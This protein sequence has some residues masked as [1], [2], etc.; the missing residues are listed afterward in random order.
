MKGINRK[1][2][3]IAM[4]GC[5]LNGVTAIAAEERV[6][7]EKIDE[8]STVTSVA[9]KERLGERRS[10]SR[11][12]NK[13]HETT[14]NYEL[15]D[16]TIVE[17]RILSTKGTFSENLERVFSKLDLSELPSGM[18]IETGA[19]FQYEAIQQKSGIAKSKDTDEENDISFTFSEMYAGLAKSANGNI[20]S[21]REVQQKSKDNFKKYNALPLAVSIVNYE[22]VDPKSIEDGRL[23][24]VNGKL[25]STSAEPYWE[26]NTFVDAG[27]LSLYEQPCDFSQMMVMPSDMFLT[28]VDVRGKPIVL[29]SA[30]MSF[31]GGDVS[32]DIKPDTPFSIPADAALLD[33]NQEVGFV[34]TLQTSA[35]SYEVQ[36]S[37]FFNDCLTQYLATVA[38][39]TPADGYSWAT[40]GPL[41][42]LDPAPHCDLPVT[43]AN[44]PYKY[45]KG[46][47][48]PRVYPA[49][50]DTADCDKLNRVMVL[51]DGIDIKNNR[52]PATL[53]ANFGEDINYFL[54]Q[55]FDVI[56]LNYKVG[57]TYVQRNGEAFRTFMV[58]TLPTL[59]DSNPDTTDVALLAG[60]MGGQVANYGLVHAELALEEHY[61]RLF[62]TLDTEYDG[63]N[64][65]TGLQLGMRF[66]GET[67][68]RIKTAVGLPSNGDGV[69]QI[70][71]APAARQLLKHNLTSGNGLYGQHPLYAELKTEISNLE[72]PTMSRNVSIANG[73]GTGQVYAQGLKTKLGY[74]EFKIPV[75]LDLL[76]D[77]S[78]DHEGEIFRGKVTVFGITI[79]EIAVSIQGAM[80]DDVQPGSSRPTPQEIADP[81]NKVIKKFT[82]NP[83][84]NLVTYGTPTHSF[85]PTA[86]ALGTGFDFSYYEKCNT[87]HATITVGNKEVISKEVIA[88]KNG[89]LPVHK[90]AYSQPC[91]QPEPVLC[92][93]S[94]EW[95]DGTFISPTVYGD[96]CKI[97]DVPTGQAAFLMGQNYY[98]PKAEPCHYPYNTDMSTGKCRIAVMPIGNTGSNTAYDAATATINFY[99]RNPALYDPSDPSTWSR[100]WWSATWNPGFGTLTSY[101]P[102]GVSICGID[103][104][105]ISNN[106]P[107]DYYAPWDPSYHAV[108]KLKMSQYHSPAD[109]VV[110]GNKFFLD[111][112]NLCPDGG[113]LDAPGCW[114]GEAP[115]G[116]TPVLSGNQFRYS[117]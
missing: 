104:T 27:M 25:L 86:S 16:G 47:V 49:S 38:H 100:A 28:N 45:V 22:R 20:P 78:T 98:L 60:S 4:I 63:A 21:L 114:M 106:F 39:Q 51:L 40:K 6:T 89:V 112:G 97:A 37:L 94:V 48:I 26:S 96:Y 81:I 55:G 9:A 101:P 79:N 116:V 107:N 115:A 74:F 46:G 13:L 64:I 58:H 18:L 69:T 108:C 83:N 31:V 68:H 99:V 52:G 67:L 10:Q 71:E 29:Q 34:L 88:L 43:L 24:V 77:A 93:S 73:S 11:D 17:E 59:M 109:V 30:T 2:A 3:T 80:Q 57:N 62:M 36:T 102:V 65:P 50:G 90:L 117:E 54:E 111:Q 66:M 44:K 113:I 1:L 12:W 42:Q 84:P 103:Y 92:F 19:I 110:D 82:I 33:G 75:V 23:K 70:L 61:T 105:E 14:S 72:L 91:G 53:W 76:F 41:L 35:G 87:G 5:M 95:W 8:R 15:Y 7:I 85:V 56:T 32:I